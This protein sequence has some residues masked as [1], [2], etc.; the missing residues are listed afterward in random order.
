MDD[1]LLMGL[2]SALKNGYSEYKD[3]SRDAEDRALKKRSARLQMAQAG[4][5]ENPDG[6]FTDTLDKATDK[7]LARK[8]TTAEIAKLEAEAESKGT[9]GLLDT[10]HKKLTNAK[11]RKEMEDGKKPGQSE[12]AA[13]G[14]SKRLEQAEDVFKQAAATGFDPT[15]T[16][17]AL[18][19]KIPDILGGF[20]PEGL[21]LQ[22]QAEKNF[23]NAVLRRESGASISPSEN[24]SGVKQYFPR[25]G[26]SPEV[27]RQK[28]INRKIVYEGMRG[29]S[30]RAYEKTPSA[31]QIAA[32]VPKKK[33]AGL[34]QEATA[35]ES[36]PVSQ[37]QL[38][39]MSDE[40]IKAH[41][42]RVKGVK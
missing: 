13:A 32:T 36:K 29:E 37:Q 11:L 31:S 33:A 18:Q 34:I 7:D 6:S 3:V 35:S 17:A 39:Q 26:D 10:E 1:G 23:L 9:V 8:K 12:F 30:G 22:E 38:E 28:E 27:L 19:R 16:K 15:S 21:Q 14:Y 2:A 25:P 5:D 42:K 24:E 41:W 40:E 4:M 20:K